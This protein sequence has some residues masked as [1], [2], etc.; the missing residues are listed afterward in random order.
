MNHPPPLKDLYVYI[1]QSFTGLR[2]ASQHRTQNIY[3]YRRSRRLIISTYIFFSIF[4]NMYGTMYNMQCTVYNV[5]YRYIWNNMLIY[6]FF[7]FVWVMCF[8]IVK[9]QREQGNIYF[10]LLSILAGNICIFKTYKLKYK[11]G[12]KCIWQ[13]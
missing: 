11:G 1:Y 5:K 4:A 6:I 12:L 9:L 8:P 10:P 3:H 7:I 13:Y 2:A